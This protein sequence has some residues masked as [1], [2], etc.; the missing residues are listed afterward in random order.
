VEER[1]GTEE[2][3]DDDAGA[4]SDAISANRAWITTS[5]RDMSAL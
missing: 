4:G 5:S 1:T 2:E 3:D